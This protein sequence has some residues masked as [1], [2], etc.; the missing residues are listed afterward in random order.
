[1]VFKKRSDLP[2][3][4]KAKDMKAKVTLP[5][6][7]VPYAPKPKPEPAVPK[8]KAAPPPK[9]FHGMIPRQDNKKKFPV[10]K[11]TSIEPTVMVSGKSDFIFSDNGTVVYKT[12]AAATK[13][14]HTFR[15]R[16]IADYRKPGSQ[17]SV[18]DLHHL[19]SRNN[20]EHLVQ[21]CRFKVVYETPDNIPDIGGHLVKIG[22]MRLVNVATGEY[23]SLSS[24]NPAL[25]VLMIYS[26]ITREGI[27][28]LP[29]IVI[30]HE[31]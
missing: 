8:A 9:D 19:L 20:D 22:K 21:G 11:R 15:L 28:G 2:P 5:E 12:P 13:W 6:L 7:G 14:P 24:E 3:S 17:V 30:C 18:N 23:I 26:F 16:V 25:R 29:K 27:S 1:M 4:N 10:K 31:Q